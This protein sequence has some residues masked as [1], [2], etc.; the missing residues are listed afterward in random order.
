MGK[1]QKNSIP[2][3]ENQERRGRKGGVTTPNKQIEEKN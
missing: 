1:P 2:L 3:G